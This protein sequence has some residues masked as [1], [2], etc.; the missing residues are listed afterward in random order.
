MWLTY[1]V[2]SIYATII[3]LF[4]RLNSINSYHYYET[5]DRIAELALII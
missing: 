3:I 2:S 5:Q 1:C 4:R